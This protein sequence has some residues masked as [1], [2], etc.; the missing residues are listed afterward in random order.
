MIER[1]FSV[2]AKVKF[3]SIRLFLIKLIN[4]LLNFYLL[5][6]SGSKAF[7]MYRF[8]YNMAISRSLKPSLSFFCC[9]M[10]IMLIISSRG[11]LLRT[12][13][14]LFPCSLFVYIAVAFGRSIL[15]LINSEA[16]CRIYAKYKV[17][18]WLKYADKRT[19]LVLR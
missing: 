3:P 18:L 2:Q 6:S 9:T 19:F 8:L 5:R 17:R 12:K 11:V 13:T 7:P 15:F 10:S 14:S 1:N 4:K 16:H